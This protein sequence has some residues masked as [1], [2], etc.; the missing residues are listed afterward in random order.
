MKQSLFSFYT[1]V[2]YEYF[3]LEAP[4]NMTIANEAFNGC[5]YGYEGLDL[6]LTCRVVSGTP[7]G[8]IYW[9]YNNNIVQKRNSSSVTYVFQP[10]AADDLGE[11]L[12][13]A[14]NSLIL[15]RKVKICLSC[16]Y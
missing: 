14:N 3:I 11:F 13:E 15:Q 12:C 1:Y 9:I 6:Y 2:S 16:E 5:I 10:S 8:T 4:S 7:N